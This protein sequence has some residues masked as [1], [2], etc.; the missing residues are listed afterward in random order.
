MKNEIEKIKKLITTP[1]Y[2]T[3]DQGVAYLREMNNSQNA[4]EILLE[5]CKYDK[6]NFIFLEGG[7]YLWL[8]LVPNNTFKGNDKEQ[9]FLDYAL[10]NLI[11]YAPEESKIDD[12]I[13]KKNLTEL[14]LP[15]IRFSKFP[16]GILELEFLTSLDLYIKFESNKD[17]NNTIL[18]I[19]DNIEKLAN[20]KRLSWCG[21][22]NE[23]PIGL[24]KLKK[25]KKLSLQNN[26][27]ET[28]PEFIF[29]MT[30]IEDLI[31]FGNKLNSLPENIS[32]LVN[33]NDNGGL[34]IHTNPFIN[35]LLSKE[36]SNVKN[37][38][39][40]SEN[41]SLSGFLGKKTNFIY[42]LGQT[43]RNWMEN[44]YGSNSNDFYFPDVPDEP[45]DDYDDDDTVYNAL[46]DATINPE[47]PNYILRSISLFC[48]DK[49]SIGKDL[50]GNENCPP[51]VIYDIMNGSNNNLKEIFTTLIQNSDC[52]NK[53][54]DFIANGNNNELKKMILNNPSLSSEAVFIILKSASVG[55]EMID[56]ISKRANIDEL[57]LKIVNLKLKLAKLIQETPDNSSF[58]QESLLSNTDWGKEVFEALC[59]DENPD[60]RNALAINPYIPES[61][62]SLLF[63]DEEHKIRVTVVSNPYCSKEMLIKASSESENYLSS[64]IRK[65]VAL[66]ANA[67]KEVIDKLLKDK[68]RWVRESAASHSSIKTEEIMSIVEAQEKDINGVLTGDYYLLKG[69]LNNPNCAEADKAKINVKLKS[70]GYEQEFDTYTLGFNCPCYPSE[71]VAGDVELD[72]VITAITE[73]EGDWTGYVWDNDWY[74]IDNYYHSYGMQDTARDVEYPDGTMESIYIA[75]NPDDPDYNTPSVEEIAE[76][77]T[78][79]SFFSTGCSYE[80]T[81]DGW[82]NW[83]KYTAEI[84]YELKVDKIIPFYEYGNVSYYEYDE[85]DAFESNGDY[86]TR[87]QGTD[88]CL[89]MVTKDKGVIVADLEEII[90]EINEAGLNE[91]DRDV[92]RTFLE[93]NYS[94]E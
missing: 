76:R 44:H 15:Q 81:S 59:Q 6:D 82:N 20:L 42:L 34:S 54:L 39:S 64:L 40:E 63:K 4:F 68:Y 31:I 70:A 46:S 1:N 22:L 93:K 26:N 41:L 19:P 84:E 57:S 87:G 18:P 10:C 77:L 80:K 65:A 48:R 45:I 53:I 49:K 23:L 86:S 88:F 33:L 56:I 73:Y 50:L 17:K 24:S 21:N 62:I 71:D 29:K 3:I 60:I 78:P 75:P 13:R 58:L 27:F 36:C 66:N 43:L 47:T 79:G 7:E 25:L 72:D 67:P 16:Q 85:M 92:V 8:P 32:N 5:G 90:N 2:Q 37:L 83:M 51:G 38:G 11:G 55:S 28:I 30:W 61:I 52:N 14:F 9:P 35:E 74:G 69:L 89:Y 91:K 12:S 94:C